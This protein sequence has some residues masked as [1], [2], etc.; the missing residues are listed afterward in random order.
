[1]IQFKGHCNLDPPTSSE[2]LFWPCKN[3]NVT[4]VLDLLPSRGY[5]SLSVVN[6]SPATT[7]FVYVYL[8]Y[9]IFTVKNSPSICFLALLLQ[10]WASTPLI[11]LATSCGWACP[12]PTS[13]TCPAAGYGT[14]YRTG[15]ALPPQVMLP[16][17]AC[18][19]VSAYTVTAIPFIYS[20][21][22]NCAANFHIHVSVSDLYIPRIGP[23]ISSS[24]TG[25]PIVGVYNS[26]T[27]TW[28]WKLG[29]RPRY[30]FSGNICHKF[31]AFCLCSVVG[32]TT[33]KL[34]CYLRLSWHCS[35]SFHPPFPGDEPD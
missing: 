28:K 27:D 26:L 1:M 16:P 2:V 35:I 7:K 13:G 11:I 12:V 4:E 5:G 19:W 34:A 8:V 25:R 14:W 33:K 6:F 24:R 30:S 18:S 31:S 29:L 22:G 3:E 32:I 20:F 21:S 9:N 10:I 23:H 17:P 15:Q